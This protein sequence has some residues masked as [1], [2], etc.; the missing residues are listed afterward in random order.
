MLVGATGLNG[1]FDAIEVGWLAP[2][3]SD[4]DRP[5]NGALVPE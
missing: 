2:C 4:H 5:K 3:A 1:S